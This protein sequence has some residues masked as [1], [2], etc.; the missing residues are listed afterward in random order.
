MRPKIKMVDNDMSTVPQKNFHL[1]S[2]WKEVIVIGRFGLVGLA[3]T[4]VHLGVVWALI[5]MTDLST[6]I[7][8]TLAFLA[9]FGVSFA[10]H[11]FWTFSAP[12]KLRKAIMRFL[13]I[14]LSGFAANSVLLAGLLKTEWFS[15]FTSAAFAI[16]VV[17]IITFLASRLWGFKK[18]SVELVSNLSNSVND[19]VH[20][21]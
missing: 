15:A 19:D 7:A 21:H 16:A 17:P 8:N 3:A 13:L 2:F 4:A 18:S 1:N 12:G 6:L 14:S 5:G 9:A 20:G 11:Y 10:G